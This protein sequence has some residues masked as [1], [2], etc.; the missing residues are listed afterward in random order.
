MSETVVGFPKSTIHQA[1]LAVL[2]WNWLGWPL[3][4][5]CPSTALAGEVPGQIELAEVCFPLAT[6]TPF[7]SWTTIWEI[8]SQASG[9]VELRT[10]TYLTFWHEP[11]AGTAVGTKAG[12]VAISRRGALLQL[13]VLM[14]NLGPP[15]V[16]VYSV[17]RSLFESSNWTL[18][19]IILLLQQI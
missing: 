11:A 8:W 10:L 3:A 16:M 9:A 6:L 17:I 2:A 4:P 15:E 18:A 5:S 12:L 19:P 1:L 7:S 14:T 13:L